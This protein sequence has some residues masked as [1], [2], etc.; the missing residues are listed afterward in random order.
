MNTPHQALNTLHP[1]GDN[2]WAVRIDLNMGPINISTQM[3]IVRLPDQSLILLSPVTINSTLKAAI[4]AL[5]TVSHIVSPNNFHHL[6]ANDAILAFPNAQYVCSNSLSKRIK[7]LP[8]HIDL[9]TLSTSTWQN[10]LEIIRVSPSHMGDEVVFFHKESKT[11]IITDLFQCITGKVNVATRIFACLAGVRNNFGISRLFK[12]MIK[13]KQEFKD[14]FEHMQRW[15]YN[16]V[17]LP[18]NTNITKDAKQ[19]VQH[20]IDKL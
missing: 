9:H 8:Q 17:L 5:G 13:N 14:S 20:A 7:S 3:T 1:F 16:T 19:A 18:H 4:N 10:Q 15:E 2:I 11:L 12:T 6:Y